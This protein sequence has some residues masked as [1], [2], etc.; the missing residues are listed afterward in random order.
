VFLALQAEGL[1]VVDGQQAMMKAREIK[2]PD[3]ILL[4]T[5]ACA[6][7]DGVY[8]DIFEALKPG[9]GSPTSWAWP[10]PGCSR[11]GR[12]SSRRS[13]RS[14]GSAAAPSPRVLGSSDSPR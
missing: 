7:V 10:T 5:Q 14:P 11:W 9:V 13:T 12:S 1:N 4:L 2:S 3:E 8:Q 6:M